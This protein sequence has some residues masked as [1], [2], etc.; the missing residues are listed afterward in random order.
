MQESGDNGDIMSGVGNTKQPRATQLKKWFFTWNNFPEDGVEILRSKFDEI[1]DKYVF[2]HEQGE[3]SGIHHLQGTIFL[4]KKMRWSEFKLPKQINWKKT[5]NETA[6][7][8][9]C[10][11]SETRIDGPWTK[12]IKIKKPL[13]LITPDREYQKFILDIIKTEPDERSVYWFY[14]PKG[15]VGKSSFC[16]YMAAK[17]NALFIDEGKKADLM[18]HVINFSLNNEIE[19]V[20]LDIPRANFNKISYK[21]IESIK[22]GL[23]YSSKYEGG[24]LI[25]NSP[26]VIIFCNFE[27]EY[28]KLS[29]DRWNVY[30]INDDYS[31]SKQEL[32]YI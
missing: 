28:E 9:Y 20:V 25:F 29:D 11:K 32:N 10:S 23:I 1:C 5:N 13:K 7:I 12:G 21:S 24:Q 22:T 8:D 26:H 3:K 27:P 18:H 14:E 30:R 31:I 19:L 4:K 2:Q 6:A 17:H 15:N 16:K